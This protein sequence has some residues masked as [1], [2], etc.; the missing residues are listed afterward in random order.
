[1]RQTSIEAYNKIK[2]DGLLSKRRLQVYDVVY[3]KGPLTVV[4]CCKI[5]SN[6]MDTRSISPRFTE[7]RNLGVFSEIG[8]RQCSV[9][10]RNVIL[11]DVTSLLPVKPKKRMTLKEKY[12]IAIEA[13]KSIGLE[14]TQKV[15]KELGE[16]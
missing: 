4:E 13:L 1:M 16:L 12:T 5:L 7:L 11:W 8:V 9:T 2:Q 3:A 14:S 10:G 6:T 15:L